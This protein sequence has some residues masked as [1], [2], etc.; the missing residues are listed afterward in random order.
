MRWSEISAR[1]PALG[2][3]AD[4]LLIQPGVL[5]AGTIRRDG[6]AR[7]SGVEPLVPDGD[8]W[9]SMMSGSAKSRDLGLARGVVIDRA[10][11][12]RFEPPRGPRAHVSKRVVAVHDDRPGP[13][14][15]PGPGVQLLERQVDRAGQ[16]RPAVLICGQ[17]LDQLSLLACQLAQFLAP[18]PGRHDDLL[19]LARR[20]SRL[21]AGQWIPVSFPAARRRDTGLF[22]ILVSAP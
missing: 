17:H 4:R 21:A 15:L 11:P 18:D 7:I 9:L 8:L 19:I 22:P 12:G 5:L 2:A 20:P 10:E 3:V 13:V 6:A 14:Q 1:Q 16:V